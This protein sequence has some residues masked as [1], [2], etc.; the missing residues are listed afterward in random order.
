MNEE[1]CENCKHKTRLKHNFQVGNG[2]EETFCCTLFSKEKDGF[3]VQV[4]LSDMCE[5]Y[6]KGG[7]D[8]GNL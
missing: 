2:F 4:E 6:E 5:M 3:V 1:R 7:A 8:N